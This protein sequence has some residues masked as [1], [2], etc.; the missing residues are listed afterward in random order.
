M[1]FREISNSLCLFYSTENSEG[2][3]KGV[4]GYVFS[5]EDEARKALNEIKGRLEKYSSE[6]KLNIPQDLFS[7]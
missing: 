4:V 1:F 5:E 7:K 3:F 2:G 6:I